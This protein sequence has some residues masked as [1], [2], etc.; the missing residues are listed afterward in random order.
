[1]YKTP[2]TQTKSS[3]WLFRHTIWRSGCCDELLTLRWVSPVVPS[4]Q[5]INT[6]FRAEGNRMGGSLPDFLNKIQK[7]HGNVIQV[8]I[9]YKTSRQ[10]SIHRY[11]CVFCAEKRLDSQFGITVTNYDKYWNSPPAQK[12]PTV[13]PSCCSRQFYPQAERE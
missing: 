6:H 7:S 4:F 1:M 13:I 12:Q 5:S 10:S 2:E 11:T 8:A 9:R 3:L